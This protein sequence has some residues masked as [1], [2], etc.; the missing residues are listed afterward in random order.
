MGGCK[1]ISLKL[2]ERHEFNYLELDNQKQSITYN[3][4]YVLC[5]EWCL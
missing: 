1:R 5:N 3:I 2:D 4:R